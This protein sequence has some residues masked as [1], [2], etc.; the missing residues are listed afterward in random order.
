M[1]LRENDGR[2]IS[3]IQFQFLIKIIKKVRTKIITNLKIKFRLV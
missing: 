2:E 1:V 3:A